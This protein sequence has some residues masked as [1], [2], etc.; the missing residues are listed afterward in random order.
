MSRNRLTALATALALALPSLALARAPS[1]DA[2]KSAGRL[3]AYNL[4][5]PLSLLGISGLLTQRAVTQARAAGYDVAS[6][7]DS[8]AKVGRATLKKLRECDL[9]PACLSSLSANLGGGK[10]LAG[11]LDTDDVHYVVRLVLLDLD[12]G[13]LIASAQRE[14]LI[15]SRSLE[16]SFDSMLPDLLAGKSVAPTAVTITSPQKHARGQVD[17]RPLG[18]LPATVQLSPG[19]HEF[20]AEKGNYLPTDRFIEIP[21]GTTAAVD[22]PLTLMPNH[23]DPDEAAS[24]TPEVH[25]APSP[26]GTT[27]AAPVAEPARAGGVPV[28]TWV[29]LGIGAAA[30]GAG[31]YLG[32]TEKGIANKAV[33]AN[34]DGVLDIT[35]ADAING[36]RDAVMANVCFGA[37]GVA[38]LAGAILW[39]ADDGGK[40]DPA[41]SVKAASNGVLPD[42]FAIGVAPTAHGG[43][44]S[45][46]VGF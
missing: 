10:L 26:A 34:H 32:I 35:R 12:S 28:G 45:V 39:L 3:S 22:L 6:A 33:D 2:P 13:E 7:D 36:H 40:P 9:K 44:A 30:G 17:D 41:K 1:K 8:E 23:V 27:N 18:E 14:I 24:L 21:P 20:K 29:A 25:T 4:F 11:T 31:A 38:V 16:P 5:G 42:N 43:A 19:R 15:A 37:A 46:A